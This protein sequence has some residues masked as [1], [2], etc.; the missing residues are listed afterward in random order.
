MTKSAD[1][2]P[3]V[4]SCLCLGLVD[5]FSQPT[6]DQI[7]AKQQFNSTLQTCFSELGKNNYWVR[8]FGEGALI[9]CPH[10]PE[11]ALFLAL[12]LQQLRLVGDTKPASLQLRTGLHLGSFRAND[13]LEGRTNYLGDGIATTQ[14][15]MGLAEPG[16]ILASGSFVD[17]VVSLHGD[18]ANM[19][20]DPQSQPDSQGRNYTSYGVRPDSATVQRLLQDIRDHTEHA[21]DH[22]TPAHA[23]PY[24]AAVT[25]IRNWFVP[26]N[27][28]VGTVTVVWATS[29]RL[30]LA[31]KWMETLGLALMLCGASLWLY[32]RFAAASRSAGSQTRIGPISA[33]GFGGLMVAVGGLMALISWYSVHLADVVPPTVASPS[34]TSTPALTMEAS[35]PIGKAVASPTPTPTPTPVPKTDF[36]ASEVRIRA[37]EGPVAPAPTPSATPAERSAKVAPRTSKSAPSVD[38]SAARTPSDPNVERSRCTDQLIRSSLGDE[39]SNSDKQ[40][41]AKSCR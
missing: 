28:L 3:I 40:E 30:G 29:Q 21:S 37:S 24:E 13:D 8:D 35:A 25:I 33:R 7:Q 17:A 36:T 22:E 10:S 38:R 41:L 15:I 32:L 11:H 31:P 18:Y 5:F 39:L 34:A 27:A 6:S 16:E 12:R 23:S 1:S 4:A 20:V 2:R 26:F 14:R 19:F 9:V